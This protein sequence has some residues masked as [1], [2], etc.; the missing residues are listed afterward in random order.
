M[1][2]Q[3]DTDQRWQNAK[4][5]VRSAAVATAVGVTA[6]AAFTSMGSSVVPSL[7]TGAIG[8]RS[9]FD[10]AQHLSRATSSFEE[11]RILI[12]RANGIIRTVQSNSYSITEDMTQEWDEVDKCLRDT[13]AELSALESQGGDAA[14]ETSSKT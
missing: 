12:A 7:A 14:K 5:V 10:W 1:V 4:N 8:A 11:P 3:H 6:T 2:S 9:A 13:I